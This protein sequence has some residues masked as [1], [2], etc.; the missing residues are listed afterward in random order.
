MVTYAGGTPRFI[1]LHP[2]GESHTANDW[3]IDFD[4]L[5][6]MIN[7]KEGFETT[8]NSNWSKFC[9]KTLMTT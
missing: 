1:P 4:K 6:E 9:S 3:C 2:K 5:E 7:P 8:K